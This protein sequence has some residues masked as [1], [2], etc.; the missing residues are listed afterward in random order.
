MGAW[1]ANAFCC[2]C[3]VNLH[4]LTMH[5]MQMG[6]G[7]MRIQVRNHETEES[8][9]FYLIRTDG[10]MDD[11]S[12]FKCINRLFPAYGESRNLPVSGHAWSACRTPA[13]PP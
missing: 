1:Q 2:G 13:L 10:S 5:V 11:F 3:L 9:C 4:A 6:S 7:V 12:V 8:N